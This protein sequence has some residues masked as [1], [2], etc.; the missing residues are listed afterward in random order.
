MLRCAKKIVILF[1]GTSWLWNDRWK[2]C[3]RLVGGVCAKT[4]SEFCKIKPIVRS[5]VGCATC[6]R[7][8]QWKNIQLFCSTAWTASNHSTFWNFTIAW[9]T[10]WNCFLLQSNW[11]KSEGEP[12]IV[13]QYKVKVRLI[14]GFASRLVS[15]KSS[16]GGDK[17]LSNHIPMI[18][19][20]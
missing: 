10:F 6:H 14:L 3:V 1:N 9:L 2:C 5:Y 13:V 11:T 4:R 16:R 12:G 15:G 19:R 20:W 8:L 7:I 18:F 17:N